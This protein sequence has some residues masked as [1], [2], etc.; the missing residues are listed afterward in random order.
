M[1]RNFSKNSECKCSAERNN[2]TTPKISVLLPVFND[3]R[4]L[5]EALLS[6]LKQSFTDFEI[7]AIDDGSTDSS[8]AMLNSYAAIDD[9]IKVETQPNMGIGKTLNRAIQLATA[10]LLARHDSDDRSLPERFDRQVNYLNAHPN[11][12]LLG[13]A[14]S[15]IDAE[16]EI[17]YSPNIV[18]GNDQ[19]INLL[20][21]TSPFIHGSVMMRR[22]VAIKA[23]C[24]ATIRWYEDLFLWRSLARIAKVENIDEPLYQYRIRP[25]NLH[26][27]RKIQA[28]ASKIFRDHWPE[29]KFSEDEL[30]V[31]ENLKTQIT[32]TARKAQ[33]CLNMSK[34]LMLNNGNTW[35]ARKFL[36]KGLFAKPNTVELWFHLGLSLLPRKLS[37]AWRRYRVDTGERRV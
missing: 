22:S 13:T 14:V 11:I 7:I 24:Y 15:I 28:A 19:L 10:N 36:L 26:I 4:Y 1:W 8:L 35:E 23:G 18:Q 9:R 37:A 34:G 32:P 25:S 5:E 33:F 30:E 6:I 29:D 3:E 2:M 16:G 27:P 20:K 31:L 21:T 12:A 17:K